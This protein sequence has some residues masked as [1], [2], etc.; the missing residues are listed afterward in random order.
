M[1]ISIDVLILSGKYKYLEAYRKEATTA[2]H[3]LNTKIACHNYNRNN[4]KK[5][6]R[7]SYLELFGKGDSNEWT[8]II[9]DLHKHCVEREIPSIAYIIKQKEGISDFL[10]QEFYETFSVSSG[11]KGYKEL[12]A[13]VASY[14]LCC[15]V[16]K[17]R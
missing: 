10:Q 15:G 3:R 11:Y 5:G 8:N 1:E 9:Y 16:L 6:L 2:I 4:L 13:N 7:V 14:L 12:Q 17:L